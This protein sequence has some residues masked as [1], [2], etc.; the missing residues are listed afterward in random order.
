MEQFE[1]CI[2][3]VISL[4]ME[5]QLKNDLLLRAGAMSAGGTRT[6]MDDAA[7]RQVRS[8]LSAD[9]TSA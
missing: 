6:R 3:E 1:D 4:S 8:A 5:Q 7:G 2:E 9:S